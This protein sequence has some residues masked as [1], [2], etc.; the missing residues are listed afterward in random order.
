MAKI[1]NILMIKYV[2]FSKQLNVDLEVIK[3]KRSTT[4]LE[5]EVKNKLLLLS[6]KSFDTYY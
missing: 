5:V 6:F 4:F 2:E 1:I 3:S